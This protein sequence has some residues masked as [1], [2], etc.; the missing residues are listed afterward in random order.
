MLPRNP[1]RPSMIIINESG[2][3]DP[4]CT[5]F[6]IRVIVLTDDVLL[7]FCVSLFKDILQKTKRERE[8]ERVNIESK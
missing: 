6:R 2:V 8:R 1:I 7:T 5:T 4:C 3:V